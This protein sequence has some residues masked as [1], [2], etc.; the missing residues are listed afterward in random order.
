MVKDRPPYYGEAGEKALSLTARSLSQRQKH[1][2]Y[3]TNGK[4]C[5]IFT[6]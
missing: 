6:R 4:D 1:L 5:I 3:L 2:Y